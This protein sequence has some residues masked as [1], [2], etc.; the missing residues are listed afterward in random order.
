MPNYTVN[1]Y[2]SQIQIVGLLDLVSIQTLLGITFPSAEVYMYPGVVKHIKKH[3]PGIFEQYHHLIPG[4]IAKPDYVGQNPKEPNSV[5]LYK[6]VNDHLLMAIKLDPTGYLY[7][8]SFYDLNNGP[9][10]VA[11]RLSSGRIVPFVPSSL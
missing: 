5:E 2:S 4:M 7:L 6:V 9:Y 11:Q 10:K 8:S 3:H 1:P